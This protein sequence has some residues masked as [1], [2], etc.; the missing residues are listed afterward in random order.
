MVERGSTWNFFFFFFFRRDVMID[1]KVE[2]RKQ[3]RGIGEREEKEPS[4]SFV[5]CLSVNKNCSRLLN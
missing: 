2:G 5:S 1:P 3:G 4:L